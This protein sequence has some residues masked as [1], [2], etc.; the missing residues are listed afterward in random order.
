MNSEEHDNVDG[1]ATIWT[2]HIP[3]EVL[4]QIPEGKVVP[5]ESV[6]VWIDPLDATQEYTGVCVCVCTQPVFAWDLN[7]SCN[8]TRMQIVPNLYVNFTTRKL[9]TQAP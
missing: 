4:D 5:A 2:P 9:V 7:S 1:E 6:T 3:K 8:H